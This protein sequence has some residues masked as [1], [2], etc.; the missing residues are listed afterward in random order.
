MQQQTMILL[1]VILVLFLGVMYYMNEQSKKAAEF[2]ARLAA[3][4]A[5]K[6]TTVLVRDGGWGWGG[7]GGGWGGRRPWVRGG[8]RYW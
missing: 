1:A 7:W 5:E 2:E 6:P 4:E 8:R 3:E